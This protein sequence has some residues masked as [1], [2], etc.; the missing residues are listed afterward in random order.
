[1]KLR[2]VREPDGSV[3]VGEARYRLEE[4]NDRFVV[5]GADDGQELGAFRVTDVAHGFEIEA[6]DAE[7]GV[8]EAIAKLF[9]APRGLLPLQ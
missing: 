1:M 3:A 8:V 4:R 7:R 6:G 2:A 9:S 5:V